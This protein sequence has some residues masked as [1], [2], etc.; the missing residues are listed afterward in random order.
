MEGPP[1][2]RKKKSK[3]DTHQ[4]EP[5][6]QYARCNDGIRMPPPPTRS[7]DMV[8]DSQLTQVRGDTHSVGGNSRGAPSLQDS[9]VP[10]GFFEDT[11]QRPVK[12]GATA[13]SKHNGDFDAFMQEISALGAVK[14]NQDGTIM[15]VSEQAEEQQG[16]E[17]D[18][19]VHNS[20]GD[21]IDTFEQFVREERMREIKEAV[22]QRNSAVFEETGNSVLAEVSG[23]ASDNFI[24]VPAISLPVERKSIAESYNEI[25][26]Q[27]DESSSSD[28]NDEDGW[29]CKTLR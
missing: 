18:D 16:G 4:T 26:Q 8:T 12:K 11:S 6:S 21:D 28:D 20:T 14:H 23:V 24:S 29:R 27:D 7:R 2:K 15:E 1:P 5:S 13:Q 3:G 10:A 22:Q 25:L 17:G 9:S 19:S